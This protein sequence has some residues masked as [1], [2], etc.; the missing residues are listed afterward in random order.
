MRSMAVM[1]PASGEWACTVVMVPKL[2][3]SILFCIYDRKLNLMTI[4]DAYPISR[5]DECIESLGEATIIS[6]LHCAAGY[7]QITVAE[8][9]RPHLFFVPSWHLAV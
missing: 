9:D 8:E 7:W 1:D 6:T 3:G 4:K 2:D 5:M